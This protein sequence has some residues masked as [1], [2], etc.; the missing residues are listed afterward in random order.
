MRRV[1][2]RGCG[3]GWRVEMERGKISFNL[4]L[5]NKRTVIC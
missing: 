5:K 2:G 4:K 3:R 1:R